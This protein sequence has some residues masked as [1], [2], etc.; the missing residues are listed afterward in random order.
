MLRTC[1]PS[2]RASALEITVLDAPVSTSASTPFTRPSRFPSAV[3]PQMS[4]L[5][6]MLPTPPV[7]YHVIPT[8]A[9]AA[10]CAEASRCNRDLGG[11]A[12]GAVG[13]HGVDGESST[14]R[15][16]IEMELIHRIGEGRL[17]E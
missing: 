5:R 13:R 16:V 10:R 4:T 7:T 3:R 12:P 2:L 8:L 11:E 17:L 14:L 9:G 6:E 1:P 15:Q